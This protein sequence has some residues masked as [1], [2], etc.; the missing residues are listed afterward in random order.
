M[1]EYRCWM[2]ANCETRDDAR[3][4]HAFDA[5]SASKAFAKKADEDSGAEMSASREGFTVHVLSEDDIETVWRVWP[6]Y[7][8]QWYAHAERVASC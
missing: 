1:A 7:E 4:V 8:V 3:V 6:E 2:P 5:W